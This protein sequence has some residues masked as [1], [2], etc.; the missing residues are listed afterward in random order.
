M[1]GLSTLK[2]IFGKNKEI[3]KG[4]L[5]AENGIA[6]AKL[7]MNTIEAVSSDNKA[8]PL[9][10]G[11]P[12]SGV[13]IGQG[14][15]G[16]VNII[17]ATQKGL[18]AL[19]GGSAGSAPSMGAAGGGG[20]ATAPQFN[21]VGNTGVNQLAATLG[22][23]QPPIKTYVTAGDVSSGQSLNRNIITNASLG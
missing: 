11:M 16:A 14:I 18:A 12:W 4:V 22:R 1:S 8:S 3:Q 13:H 23:E 15:L 9:T 2:N 21:V 6:L 17:S 7:T 20:G 5:L 10:F 19:G